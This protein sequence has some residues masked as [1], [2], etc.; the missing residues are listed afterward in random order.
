MCRATHLVSNDDS[1]L[2]RALDLVHLND[3]P[4]T[5]LDIPHDLLVYVQGIPAGLFEKD[6]VG[7]GTNVGLAVDAG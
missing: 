1:T 7:D 2:A 4:V 3:G 6:G 5:R